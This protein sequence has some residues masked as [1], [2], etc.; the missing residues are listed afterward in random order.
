MGI[1][2]WT[3]EKTIGSSA[4]A[5]MT[6]YPD[7]SFLDALEQSLRET[8]PGWHDGLWSMAAKEIPPEAGPKEAIKA[9]AAYCVRYRV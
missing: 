4:F 1:M 2:Q 8:R 5:Y 7:M 3:T 6:K 9:V